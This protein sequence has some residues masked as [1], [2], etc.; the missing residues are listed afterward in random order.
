M[1]DNVPTPTNNASTS[2]AEMDALLAMVGNLSQ[3]SLNL[4]RVSSQALLCP[5]DKHGTRLGLKSFDFGA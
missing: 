4:T 2:Q 3:M 5:G 1:A